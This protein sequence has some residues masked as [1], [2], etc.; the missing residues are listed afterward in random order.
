VLIG[1]LQACA[2]TAPSTPA[3]EAPPAAAPAAPPRPSAMAVERQWLQSWFEGTPV[4][5]EQQSTAAFGVSVPRR[6]CF[7]PGASQVLPP[8]AALLDKVAQSLKRQ[9][10]ARLLRVAAPGDAGA[11]PALAL[12][13]AEAVR[14]QLQA[15][16][17]PAHRLA[18]AR[19]GDGDAV[20][21]RI[22]F[23]M[24]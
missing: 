6:Y 15:Q 4:R 14:R 9:P 21:L 17:V 5:I 8:L 10:E 20:V 19:A 13:R 7:E 11:S 18:A 12:Q 24:P 23:A 1:L 2:G 22:G 3:P 16:G